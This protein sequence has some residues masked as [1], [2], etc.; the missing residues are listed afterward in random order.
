MNKLYIIADTFYSEK[1]MM[2]CLLN[3]YDYHVINV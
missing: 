3:V 2:K 1:L